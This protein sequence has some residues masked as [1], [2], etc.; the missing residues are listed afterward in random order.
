MS[1]VDKLAVVSR[2][3]YYW[4]GLLLLALGLESVALYYQYQL[5]YWPCLLC[6]HVR[7]GVAALLLVS[8]LA[9]FVYRLPLLRFVMHALT[10][11][12]LLG[13]LERAWQ[14]LGVERG[15]IEGSCTMDPG[16][17]AWLPLDQ[18]LPKVFKVWEPCGYTPPLLAGV[19]MAEALLVLFA[20]LVVMSLLMTVLSLRQTQQG[21]ES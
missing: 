12:L 5:E 15:F 8:V 17:P 20:V 1:F 6:I 11:L 14:L 4:L 3:R 13:L 9:L 19:T 21:M 2:S 18:W 16:F 10:T 7:V